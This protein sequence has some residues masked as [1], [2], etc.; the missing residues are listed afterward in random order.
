MSAKLRIPPKQFDHYQNQQTLHPHC[1]E[2]F[3]KG[4]IQIGAFL[5]KS[6]WTEK[7]GQNWY[8][9]KITDH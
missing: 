9:F 7:I 4:R 6:S 5:K 2:Y 8:I 3:A 1:G